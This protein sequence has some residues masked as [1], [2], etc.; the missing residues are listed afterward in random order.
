MTTPDFPPALPAPQKDGHGIAGATEFLRTDFETG[1]ARQRRIFTGSF[2]KM[3][4]SWVL[5]S[6]ELL[7]YREFYQETISAGTRAFKLNLWLDNKFTNAVVRFTA[8]PKE[9]FMGPFT[10]KVAGEVEILQELPIV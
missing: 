6:T 10:W 8:R 3:N 9:D 7:T 5:T 4:V 2:A 1:P